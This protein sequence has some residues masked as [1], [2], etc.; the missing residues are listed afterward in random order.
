MG[1]GAGS[2]QITPRKEV[3]S[4]FMSSKKNLEN[5]A[6]GFSGRKS[7]T[8]VLNLQ[9]M[10]LKQNQ[11]NAKINHCFGDFYKK[12]DTFADSGKEG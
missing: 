2:G 9:D 12:L 3:K 8:R 10:N 11:P 6:A 7:P 1:Y 4:T 5:L